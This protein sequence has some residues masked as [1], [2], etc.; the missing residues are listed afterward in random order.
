VRGHWN[1]GWAATEQD[2]RSQLCRHV[3]IQK[4]REMIVPS[5]TLPLRMKEFQK[6]SGFISSSQYS[7][8][9]RRLLFCAFIRWLRE[10]DISLKRQK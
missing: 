1:P 4:R 3:P 8:K 10:V 9:E 6:G 2:E 5:S 7:N